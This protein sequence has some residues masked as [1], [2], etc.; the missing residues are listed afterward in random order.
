MEVEAEVVRC[1][2]EENGEGGRERESRARMERGGPNLLIRKGGD[3]VWLM[4]IRVILVI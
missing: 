2:E 4:E 1:E 3:R